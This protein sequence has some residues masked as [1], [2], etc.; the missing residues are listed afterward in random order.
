MGYYKLHYRTEFQGLPISVENRKGSK[1]SWYDPH[2][3]EE[4]HTKMLY[5][6]GYIRGTIGADGD[7]VDV[8]VGNNKKSN[9]VFVITQKKAPDF[10]TNDE[11]KI[12]LGFDSEKEAK[13][14][15]AKHYDNP[16]FF[17]SIKEMSLD[18]FKEKVFDSKG[19][20]IKGALNK[21]GNSVK[22]G[23]IMEKNKKDTVSAIDEDEMDV[24][25][26]FRS[27]SQRKYMYAA[28]DR[29]EIPKDVVE[30]FSDKTPKNAD[31]PEKV[32]KK[33]T[34]DKAIKDLKQAEE[35]FKAL[36]SRVVSGLAKRARMQQAVAEY[37][38]PTTYTPFD[39]TEV[40]Q[41]GS[42]DEQP[43]IGTN[44]TRNIHEPPVVPVRSIDNAVFSA[45]P[46]QPEVYK[47]CDGCGYMYKSIN[48]PKCSA[49]NF[50]E[51]G[52]YWKR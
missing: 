10:K 2:T 50:G 7:E 24:K 29:G 31:L 42:A 16:R 11:Q 22:L 14:A 43:L 18:K 36:S 26:K 21:E 41:A 45:T 34:M 13:T 37:V 39:N 12:M 48:C 46:C 6:Y 40:G 9:K 32:K 5:P 51:S 38:S 17:G 35:L 4:G 28:A 27:D 1:R 19:R 15:Y 52:P 20:F 44:R 3:E 30:E 23:D 8:F 47:S 25:K 49:G 33:R